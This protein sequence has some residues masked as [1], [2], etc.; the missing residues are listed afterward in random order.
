MPTRMIQ[1]RDLATRA[2]EMGAAVLRGELARQEPDGWAIDG[3]PVTEWLAEYEGQEV[4]LIAIASDARSAPTVIR[5]TC[6]TCGRD[7]EGSECP[8]CREARLRLRGR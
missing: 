8:H 7:Y 4:Y 2:Y 3:Q 1:A 6:R 5:R